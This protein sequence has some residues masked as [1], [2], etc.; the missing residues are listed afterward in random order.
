MMKLAMIAVHN[1]MKEHC[2]QSVMLLQIHDELVF[3]MHPDE[4]DILPAM[5]KSC[6]ESA[7]SLGDI[8]VVVDIGTGTNWAEAH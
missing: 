7:Y 6:M 1:R 2:L 8:P 3:E 4:R 5:V